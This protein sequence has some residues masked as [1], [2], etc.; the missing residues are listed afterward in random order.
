MDVEAS[1]E[2]DIDCLNEDCEQRFERGELITRNEF[3][4][5]A[6]QKEAKEVFLK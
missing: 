5:I 4:E 6:K 3:E 1:E 2:I